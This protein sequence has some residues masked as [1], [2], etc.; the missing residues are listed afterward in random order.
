MRATALRIAMLAAMTAAVLSAAHIGLAAVDTATATEQPAAGYC[1]V[2]A[3]PID[4]STLRRLYAGPPQT[5]PAPCRLPGVEWSEL[6]ALPAAPPSPDARSMTRDEVALGRR[7]F[8]D[9]RLSRSGQIACASCHDQDLGW[10][11][12]RRVSFGHDR[13]PSR[14]NAPSVRYAAYADSLFWD[15][16][17][18]SLEEQAMAPIMH[19]GEMAFDADGFR[20]RLLTLDDYSATARALYARE[21]LQPGDVASAL[22]TF[23]RSL[24]TPRGRYQAFMKGRKQAFSDEALL[25]LHLFR[26]KAG[27]MNCHHGAS[28]SDGRFH[29]LGISFYGSERQDVGR[30]AVTGRS[31]DVGAFRTPSLLGVGET[32]PYMHAGHF[33]DLRTVLLM[34]R[35]G[36]PQPKPR[37]QQAEDVLFPKSSPLLMPI[38][39]Q[40]N[41]IQALEAFLRTL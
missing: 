9:P 17:A 13:T 40:E 27:C 33:R 11:D 32:S 24:A 2:D 35:V 5:W 3:A 37:G 4:S 18:G 6:A 7:L 12:G 30:Y 39:L 8:H 20:Q 15:G 34:Y 1:T 19:A 23:Q 29:N 16:S 14:R 25:G 10:A 41:E 31:E 22:A 38:D 28:F 21:R 36:M 26:T